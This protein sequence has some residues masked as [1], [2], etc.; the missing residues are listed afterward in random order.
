MFIAEYDSAIKG[1]DWVKAEGNSIKEI[2]VG[3]D[4]S[5]HLRVESNM[6]SEGRKLAKADAISDNKVRN[7]V[8][9]RPDF[10]VKSKA[11]SDSNNKT[12]VEYISANLSQK[13][14]KA[15]IRSAHLVQNL[16]QVGQPNP[17]QVV[18]T[19]SPPSP[20]VELKLL[21][22]HL[23]YAY[24]DNDQ[25]FPKIIANNLHWEEEQKL[26]HVLRQHKKAIGWKLLDLLRINLSICMHRILMEEE[27]RPIRQQE[28]RLNPTILDVVKKEMTK[29]LAAK[30]IYPISDSECVSLVQVVPKKSMMTVMKNQYDELEYP[31]ELKCDASNSALGAILGQRAVV[32]KQAHVIAYAFRTM[33][34]TQLNYTKIK[35]ELLEIVFSLDKFRPFLL[36]PKIIVFFDHAA[37]RFLLKKPEFPLGASRLYKEKLKSDAKY[38]IWDDPYLWRLC[39]E[40]VIRRCITGSEINLVLQFCHVAFGGGHYGSTRIA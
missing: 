9:S 38:Y 10:I 28:R 4:M 19:S 23:M 40:Q 17:K 14:S 5:I 32:D 16:N 20:P 27:A 31:F 2:K 18:Y 21:P 12:E 29:L 11:K 24:L 13:K 35:K 25:Q 6:D 37:L 33:D 8:P 26:L 36:G 15:E 34:P 39:N 1:R 7:L 30:T 3:S 22:S